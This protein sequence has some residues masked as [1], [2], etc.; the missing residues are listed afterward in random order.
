MSYIGKKTKSRSQIPM[1]MVTKVK[2]GKKV[3]KR[4]REKRVQF[5]KD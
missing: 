3:Y 4:E 2:E 1:K 5:D